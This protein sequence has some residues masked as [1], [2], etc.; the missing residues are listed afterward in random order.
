M[1]HHDLRLVRMHELDQT[2]HCERH[3]LLGKAEALDVW[4]RT[5]IDATKAASAHARWGVVARLVDWIVRAFSR[6]HCVADQ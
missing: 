5:G 1:I 6:P 4:R 3:G 2:L